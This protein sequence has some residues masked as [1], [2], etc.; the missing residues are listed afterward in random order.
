MSITISPTQSDIFTALGEFLTA[1]LPA[2]V[3]VQEGQLN[4]VSE[5][6]ATDFVVMIPISAPRISTNVD[7][8]VDAVFTGT[9]TDAVMN[10]TAVNPKFSGRIAVGSTIFGYNVAT[11]TVVTALGTGSGG[12]G[13]Y[14]VAPGGQSIGSETLAA[15]AE[16]LLDPAEFVI[17]CDVHGDPT[18][19]NAA[20]NAK[21]IDTLFRDN[22]GV[23]FF[24]TTGFDI[25]PLY[26]DDPKMIPFTN[27]NDQV[28]IRWVVD[29]HLQVN[30]TVSIPLQFADKFAI[31]P[32]DVDVTFPPTP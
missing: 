20:N 14:T 10:I 9:I 30:Q 13:I 3:I 6:S 27:E 11:N 32:I 2:G 15:G 18:T 8:Y 7:A 21:I 31:T 25:A 5:P 4:R 29:V 24:A 19:G 26:C 22:Y 16:T 12:A 1:V 28:E 23:D 17:Q